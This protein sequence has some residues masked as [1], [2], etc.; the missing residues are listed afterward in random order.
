MFCINRLRFANRVNKSIFKALFTQKRLNI[1]FQ[2]K[3]CCLVTKLQ[4]ISDY[5][6]IQDIQILPQL[7]RLNKHLVDIAINNM[8]LGAVIHGRTNRRRNCCQ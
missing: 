1:L 5:D 3:I 2:Q 6:Y 4:F 8:N 7:T